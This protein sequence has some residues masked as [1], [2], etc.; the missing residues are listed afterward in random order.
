[1]PTLNRTTRYVIVA[2]FDH[3]TEAAR[4]ALTAASV[5]TATPGAEIHLVHVIPNE[6]KGAL[7]KHAP[8]VEEIA[9]LARAGFR[10]PIVGHLSAGT[11]WR[12]IV[13]TAS[14][15]DADLVI[16]GTHG[17]EGIE[18]VTMGSVAE[19]VVQHARCPVLLVREKDHLLNR[20]PQIE[21][22][23]PDCV[24]AQQLSHG[25]TLFCAQHTTH[26]ER[27]HTYY[28]YPEPFAVGSSIIRPE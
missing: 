13:Q 27:M 21:P 12:A 23:C 11:A 1:M 5:A 6:R 26:H 17:R 28:E 19:K 24:N 14:N 2:A 8:H 7:E 10:G 15:V 20:E 18:R 4:V 9:R 3:S 22:P 16:V 25:K